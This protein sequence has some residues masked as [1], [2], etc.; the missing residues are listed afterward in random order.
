MPSEAEEINNFKRSFGTAE[1][2]CK[3]LNLKFVTGE[4][5]CGI[6]GGRI[7]SLVEAAKVLTDRTTICVWK[8]DAWE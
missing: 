6:Y 3:T 1:E 8:S 5:G 2:L 7:Q 4:R